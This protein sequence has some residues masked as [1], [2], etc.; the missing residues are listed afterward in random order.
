MGK[1]MQYPVGAILLGALSAYVAA[2]LASGLIAKT[3]FQFTTVGSRL[4]CIDGLRGYLALSVL[5]HHFIVWM[6]V[7]KLGGGWVPPQI[8]FFNAL[9]AGSVAL[10]FMVTGFVFYPRV[11]AGFRLTSWK[12]VFIG[13]FFRI[14]PAIVISVVFIA[15]VISLRTGASPNLHFLV[16]AAEWITSWSEV[17]LL[18]YPDS[19][20]LNA[21]VLWSLWYEWLFYLFVLPACAFA[22]DL[23]RRLG[24]PTVSIP[25]LL[26][27]IGWVFSK[28]SSMRLFVFLPLFAV[29]M[30]AFECQRKSGE[31]R[32]QG[33]IASV[34]ALSALMV[35]M[36]RAPF[37]YSPVQIVLYGSFFIIVACGNSLFGIL[38]TKAAKVLGECSYGIYLL[39]GTFLSLLFVEGAR[40][41]D[42][43]GAGVLPI[44]LPICAVVTLV[45]AFT[46][47]VLV[48]QPAIRLG[49]RVAAFLGSTRVRES[50]PQMNVAP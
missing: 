32:L 39:H 33:A 18:G 42:A 26:L 7:T 45:A 30:I 3:Q 21:Y 49:A 16:E 8:N 46:I 1:G 28:L 43:T 5:I 44:T 41:V 20:R 6:Q 11:L 36:T 34:I 37:P 13:R 12:A 29:G 17:D 47:H 38:N 14:V 50:D 22:M 23:A 24:M 25:I 31:G 9:G 19:G 10:F 4:G 40:I 15:T 48:E 2:T 27:L 35:G